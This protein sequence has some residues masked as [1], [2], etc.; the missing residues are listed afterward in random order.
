[1][2]DCSIFAKGPASID[3]DHVKLVLPP[4]SRIAM[5]GMPRQ[6]SLSAEFFERAWRA[7]RLSGETVG[8]LVAGRKAA[9]RLLRERESAVN[10]N[11]EDTAA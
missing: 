2:P 9:G 10:S 4:G 5:G 11:F 6:T 3:I 8:Y 7:R 1:V